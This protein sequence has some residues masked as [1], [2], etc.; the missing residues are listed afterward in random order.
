MKN[1]NWSDSFV[2][3]NIYDEQRSTNY[4]NLS[5]HY[6]ENNNLYMTV[7]NMIVSKSLQYGNTTQ[8]NN[9]YTV[10]RN[11]NSYNYFTDTNVFDPYSSRFLSSSVSFPSS[12]WGGFTITNETRDITKQ[13]PIDVLSSTI[14]MF[15]QNE[16]NFLN[17]KWIVQY[18]WAINGIYILS[19]YQQTGQPIPFTIK[20]GGR[21]YVPTSK[22]NNNNTTYPDTIRYGDLSQT[23]TNK[24][25]DSK[26]DIYTHYHTFYLSASSVKATYTVI[27]YQILNGIQKPYVNT[28]YDAVYQYANRDYGWVY[29]ISATYKNSEIVNSISMKYGCT[30]YVQWGIEG[31]GRSMEADVQ[32]WILQDLQ[33]G[34]NFK[35]CNYNEPIPMTN[36]YGSRETKE[37]S[38]VDAGIYNDSI[39]NWISDTPNNSN[40]V[41]EANVSLNGGNNWTGWRT[42]QNGGT[43][44]QLARGMNLGDGYIKFR[45]TL[46]APDEKSLPKLY[47]LN[48]QIICPKFKFLISDNEVLKTRIKEY[49][50]VQYPYNITGYMETNTFPEPYVC[51][52]SSVFNST[53]SAFKAFNHNNETAYDC[54]ASENGV[55]NG[56]L[57][58]DF[59]NLNSKRLYKYVLTSRNN[60]D[61]DSAPKNW[62]LK[63]SDNGID[64]IIIDTQ[65]NQTDWKKAESRVFIINMDQSYRFYRLEI[66]SNNGNISTVTVGELEFYS[67]NYEVVNQYW[68][69]IDNAKINKKTF[70]D[71]GFDNIEDFDGTLLNELNNV[72]ILVAMDNL[73]YIPHLEYRGFVKTPTRTTIDIKDKNIKLLDWTDYLYGDNV[74][75]INISSKTINS[76]IPKNIRITSETDN[77]LIVEKLLPISIYDDKP[78]IKASMV[79]TLLSVNITDKNKDKMKFNV[80]LNGKIIYPEKGKFTELLTGP[81]N[82]KR[83]FTSKEMLVGKVNVVTI[84]VEDQFG[85]SDSLTL[86]FNGNYSGIIFKDDKENVLN[87]DLGV[88]NKYIDFGNIF[89][90]QNTDVQ[91]ITVQNKNGYPIKNIYIKAN[92]PYTDATLELSFTNNP[93]MPVDSLTY[94]RTFYPDQ[95]GIFYARIKTNVSQ[96]I[97]TRIFTAKVTAEPVN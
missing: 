74:S 84:Y 69:S 19:V 44:E 22:P 64:W 10:N 42:L 15:Y 33:M 89:S 11:M 8:F 82:Y 25:Y 30:I 75:H 78:I 1:F 16:F 28:Y 29:P 6:D 48:L 37:I 65:I 72:K 63:A 71:Y 4:Q 45:E 94:Q 13:I 87:T 36:Y 88:I 85:L 52:C 79:N 20:F 7:N 43:I 54:W 62:Q 31:T 5:T 56:W 53:Y 26:F 77:G 86:T 46:Y 80:T 59:G 2:H 34:A 51:S 27:P 70:E 32:E 21:Y 35:M 17:E 3:N 95:T 67:L 97:S 9:N 58:Y 66:S 50:W 47:N 76:T 12:G 73:V 57:Q 91:K 38:I 49:D 90:G 18:G 14:G 41:I 93:F 81:I 96:Q 92:Q 23:I 55:T 40:I 39:I 60:S 61:T 83:N 24:F 68:Q